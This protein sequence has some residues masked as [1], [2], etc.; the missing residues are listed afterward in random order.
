MHQK[1]LSLSNR[2]SRCA[3]GFCVVIGCSDQRKDGPPFPKTISCTKAD[4]PVPVVIVTACSVQGMSIC[5][6][7]RQVPGV[8]QIGR[9]ACGSGSQAAA[10][11]CGE[12]AA[13]WASRC[14]SRPSCSRGVHPISPTCEHRRV[15]HVDK[16]LTVSLSTPRSTS[17]IRTASAQSSRVSCSE[18]QPNR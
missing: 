14:Q 10:H 15:L 13:I 6:K 4:Q 12:H 18:L 16:Q 8:K 1:D 2:G 5:V 9:H 7:G 17:K 3:L 11:N